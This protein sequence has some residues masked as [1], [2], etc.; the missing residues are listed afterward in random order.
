[1]LVFAG[2][3]GSELDLGNTYFSDSVLSIQSS[4]RHLLSVSFHFFFSF[5]RLSV[6]FFSGLASCCVFVPGTFGISLSL[7]LPTHLRSFLALILLR[8]RLSLTT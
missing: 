6:P 7:A 1:M 5:V 4:L 8:L 2:P 3:F